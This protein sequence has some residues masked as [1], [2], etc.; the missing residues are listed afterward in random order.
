MGEPALSADTQAALL[1]CASLGQKAEGPDKPLTP[2]EYGELI[3]ILELQ[4][5]GPGD[6]LDSS[7]L[8]QARR[9][10]GEV[11]WSR[12]GSLLER[13]SALAFAVESWAAKGIWV[14][15]QGDDGYPERLSKRL[16]YL[17]PPVL[18][19]VGNRQLLKGGG[20]AI[21]GSRDVD[22]TSAKFSRE[23]GSHCARQGIQVISGAARGVDSEAMA[24]ALDGGGR[25][26]GVLAE[27]LVRAAV[28]PHLRSA[29]EEGALLLATPYD[30][31]ATF[32]VGRAMGRNKYLY[33][34]SDVAVVVCSA[35]ESGGTWAGAIENLKHKWVP[36]FVRAGDEVPDGNRRLLEKG[37]LAF[38]SNLLS[39]EGELQR[40][41][42]TYAEF[43][44]HTTNQ[45]GPEISEH[46]SP[47]HV[48]APELAIAPLPALTGA[49]NSFDD[50]WPRIAALLTESQSAKNLSELLQ[51]KQLQLHRWLARAVELGLIK[52][53]KSP[54]RYVL[55]QTSEERGQGNLF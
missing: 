12:V 19:G 39:H 7:K 30:P 20:M 42:E 50:V 47:R 5:L 49:D 22:E 15:G 21:V 34:L 23:L 37:A 8:E 28:S 36:L 55:K 24:G 48:N 32:L 6:L 11:D 18:F 25:V 4:T 46:P 54:V 29:I 51:V 44:R 31:Q 41:F 1:L 17:A 14:L 3:R 10:N 43:H 45:V 16:K 38:D 33:A 26:V 40:F 13:G 52:K 35:A 27:Q 53:S 2:K 9:Q